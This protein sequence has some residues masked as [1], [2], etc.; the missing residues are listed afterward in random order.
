MQQNPIEKKEKMKKEKVLLDTWQAFMNR[1]CNLLHTRKLISH[2]CEGRNPAFSS[3][4]VQR[5]ICFSSTQPPKPDSKVN[6][7]SITQNTYNVQRKHRVGFKPPKLTGA[8]RSDRRPSRR[9]AASVWK[10]LCEIRNSAIGNCKMVAILN[11]SFDC[12]I[13]CT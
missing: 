11:Y 8:N 4:W 5:R 13:L 7:Y 9:I 10:T 3:F 12:Q 1:V 6:L 2:S